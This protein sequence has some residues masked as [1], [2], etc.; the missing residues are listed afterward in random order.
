MSAAD[1]DGPCSH[2]PMHDRVFMHGHPCMNMGRLSAGCSVLARSLNIDSM[3]DSRSLH[4]CM[5]S[6]LNPHRSAP[7]VSHATLNQRDHHTAQ[8]ATQPRNRHPPSTPLHPL[9]APVPLSSTNAARHSTSHTAAATHPI[10]Q[11]RQETGQSAPGASTG[12]CS[13]PQAHI[14]TYITPQAP[15]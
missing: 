6:V 7:E 4:Q 10:Q 5:C 1:L 9:K 12:R 15:R 2:P 3:L 14:H 11:R 8:Q 13:C